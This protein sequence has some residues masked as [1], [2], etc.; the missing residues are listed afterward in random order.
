M[1]LDGIPVSGNTEHPLAEYIAMNGVFLTSMSRAD[2]LF[3]GRPG[4]TYTVSSEHY[5][6][7]KDAFF[8]MHHDLLRITA[9][10]GSGSQT[11]AMSS[12][13]A[14]IADTPAARLVAFVRAHPSL[15]RRR[16]FTFTE[17]AL[18]KNGTFRCMTLFL[19]PIRRTR[20]STSTRIGRSIVPG[21]PY[22]QMPTSSSKKAA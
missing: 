17:Y 22:R 7:G 1:G 18:P 9:V 19:S 10:P 6:E 12:R 13:P 21:R 4:E 8:Q 3:T 11:V 16:A 2:I 14:V 5:C 15:V 20:T